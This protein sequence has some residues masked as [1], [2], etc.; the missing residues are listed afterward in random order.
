ME[1]PLDKVGGNNYLRRH[2]KR[3][4][5]FSAKRWTGSCTPLLGAGLITLDC[6]ASATPH[7]YLVFVL[8]MTKDGNIGGPPALIINDQNILSRKY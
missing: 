5:I 6:S 3:W 7:F 8:F 2:D 4:Q 1:M